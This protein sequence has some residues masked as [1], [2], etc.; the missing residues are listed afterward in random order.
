MS[1][2]SVR[3]DLGHG[4]VLTCCE[5][6][7]SAATGTAANESL[8]RL[9]KEVP[10]ILNLANANG[11]WDFSFAKTEVCFELNA[12]FAQN[13]NQKYAQQYKVVGISCM[14]L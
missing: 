6:H 14:K 2:H 3:V 4:K 8:R 11:T 7:T 13:R 12:S 1:F 9:A 10:V 5:W